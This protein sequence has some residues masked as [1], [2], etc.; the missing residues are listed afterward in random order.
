MVSGLVIFWAITICNRF[1]KYTL[2]HRSLG[3][4]EINLPFENCHNLVCMRD[5]TSQWNHPSGLPA[6]STIYSTAFVHQVGLHFGS[7][8][9]DVLACAFHLAAPWCEIK[10]HDTDTT[11]WFSTSRNSSDLPANIPQCVP[12]CLFISTKTWGNPS[13][14][15]K[16]HWICCLSALLESSKMPLILT[17]F[18][19]NNLGRNNRLALRNRTH[20]SKIIQRNL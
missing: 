9:T 16:L 8:R 6:L 10:W 4:L 7:F 13:L 15:I 2:F 5:T 12:I 11:L 3:I 1:S 20:R 19:Y 18:L 17:Y 14:I